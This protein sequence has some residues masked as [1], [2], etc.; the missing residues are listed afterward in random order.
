MTRNKLHRCLWLLLRGK[1]SK[2]LAKNNQ[3]RDLF[4]SL[5][6]VFVS[7]LTY[8]EFG[9]VENI[10]LVLN[11]TFGCL[12]DYNFLSYDQFLVP[13]NVNQYFGKLF[14]LLASHSLLV[15]D[16]FQTGDMSKNYRNLSSTLDSESEIDPLMNSTVAKIHSQKNVFWQFLEFHPF[17]TICALNVHVCPSEKS[18]HHPGSASKL[19]LFNQFDT[20][21]AIN[22]EL[23]CP[24]NCEH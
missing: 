16:P 7:H 23:D 18:S 14:L 2:K 13:L 17:M 11:K 8:V 19:I 21:L 6:C 15:D 5:V 1:I 10:Y 9:V 22:G 4:S 24:V 12:Q 20:N 3:E